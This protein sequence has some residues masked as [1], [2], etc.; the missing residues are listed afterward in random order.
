M[1]QALE[2]HVH[3]ERVMGTVVTFDVRDS[4]PPGAALAEAVRWLHDVDAEFSTYRP[5]SP[6]CRF[7]RGE[8]PRGAA[9]D[10][11]RWVVDRCALLHHET[12]GFFDAYA[13]GRFDPSALVKGWAVQRA[14]DGLRAAG[15]DRFCITAGGDVAA[16]GRSCH[17]PWRI[18]VRHP[19]DAQAIAGVIEADGDVAV[20]TSGRYER[21]DHI[22]D[23]RSGRAAAGVLSVTVV[24]P[25]LGLADAYATAAFAMGPD[26]AEWTLGLD[27]YEAMTILEDTR[28]LTTPGLHTVAA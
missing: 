26:G 7:G 2:K 17:P 19:H 15:V 21:G 11:L 12:S 24:G 18:G 20:A 4:R 22:V 10:S 13:T 6:V 3:V 9:S 14:A 5:D 8:L 23:P 16:H 27:G 1:R 28:V 25:D